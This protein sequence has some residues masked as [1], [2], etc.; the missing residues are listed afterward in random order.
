MHLLKL[1]SFMANFTGRAGCKLCKSPIEKGSLRLAVMVQ[2]RFHDGKDAHWFHS[3][4]F[5][6]KHHPPS[7]GDIEDYESLRYDDQKMIESKVG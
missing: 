7:V 3:Q 4:C 2:S 1:I 5:F 6:Q